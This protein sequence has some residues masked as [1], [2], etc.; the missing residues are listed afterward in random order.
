MFLTVPS[1]VMS[2]GVTSRV[3]TRVYTRDTVQGAVMSLETH[4]HSVTCLLSVHKPVGFVVRVWHVLP[5]V[6]RP[7]ALLKTVCV[8]PRVSVTVDQSSGPI[9]HRPAT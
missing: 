6:A 3:L 8:V 2:S 5:L 9:P 4:R 7:L 1:Q